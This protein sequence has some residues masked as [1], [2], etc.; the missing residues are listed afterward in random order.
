MHTSINDG[1]KQ[2]FVLLVLC[3]I[4]AM[5]AAIVQ[6]T[7]ISQNTISS[8]L[9]HDQVVDHTSDFTA[10]AVYGKPVPVA[11]V[12][13]SLDLYGEPEVFCLQMEDLYS[14][15]GTPYPVAK[16]GTADMKTLIERLRNY[17]SKKV[18]VYTATPNGML[19]L[20]VSEL[21]HTTGSAGSTQVW[22]S[23]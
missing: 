11:Q 15:S 20:C 16:A 21:P 9:H 18:Y 10:M 6:Y 1:F 14:A 8:K 4:F 3:V 17:T 7:I 23:P 2:A 19:Q 13:A 5:S 12:I 22:V